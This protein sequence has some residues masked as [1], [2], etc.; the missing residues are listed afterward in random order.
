MDRS[1]EKN[2]PGSPLPGG[3]FSE[4]EGSRAV[5]VSNPSVTAPKDF[6]IA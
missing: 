2:R 6:L 5:S 4:S 3:I 1:E